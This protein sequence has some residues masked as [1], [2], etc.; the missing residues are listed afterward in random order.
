MF[1]PLGSYFIKKPPFAFKSKLT[2]VLPS[3][4]GVFAM[5]V[6]KSL[7]YLK[8]SIFV[9][10]LITSPKGGKPSLIYSLLSV[11]TLLTR[12]VS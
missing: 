1:K 4:D 7:R 6:H 11:F 2:G 3:V 5:I 9:K 12:P 8:T 10:G